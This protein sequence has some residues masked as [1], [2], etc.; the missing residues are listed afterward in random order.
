MTTRHDSYREKRD[1]EKS[2]EPR[3]DARKTRHDGPPR[4]VIQRHDATNEH[5]DVRLEVA[6]VLKS[7]VVPKGPST[8]PAEKRLAIPTEDHPLEYADFEGAIPEDEYGGGTVMIWDRGTFENRTRDDDDEPVPLD[9]AVEQGH[10]VVNLDGEKLSGGYAFQ[11]ADVGDDDEENW[12][13]VKT[14]DDAADA[15]RR[16]TSTQEDSAASG[17]SMQEIAEDADAD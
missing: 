10:V 16:P 1:F 7:W 12:L 13:L 5:Y 6:G 9:K 15:R 11:R 2:P 17:R 4:F 8:D 3:G 14:R